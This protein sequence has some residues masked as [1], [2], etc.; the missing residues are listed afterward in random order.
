MGGKIHFGGG[1]F[2]FVGGVFR[3]VLG[4]FRLVGGVFRFVWR[5]FQLV[6][7]SFYFVGS[8]GVNGNG[9][10]LFVEG[11]LCFKNGLRF[12]PKGLC[13]LLFGAGTDFGNFSNFRNLAC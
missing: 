11:R 12:Y 8:L 10:K 9:H 5:V 6:L 3:F 13:C 7:G 2:R 4:S 1:L